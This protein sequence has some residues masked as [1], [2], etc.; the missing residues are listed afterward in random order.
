ME[1]NIEL[2]TC[3]DELIQNTD[4]TSKY[5]L[6]NPDY[7]NAISADTRAFIMLAS[8]L[9]TKGYKPIFWFDANSIA[10]DKLLELLNSNNI[11]D[12]NA[13]WLLSTSIDDCIL[14]KLTLVFTS[15]TWKPLRDYFKENIIVVM[16]ALFGM[17]PKGAKPTYNDFATIK[18]TQ[19][20]NIYI[21]FFQTNQ[22]SLSTPNYYFF[23]NSFS[24]FRDL[25]AVKDLQNFTI[26]SS[27]NSVCHF[28]VGYL[29]I[30]AYK[31]IKDYLPQK[32]VILFA[33]TTITHSEEFGH[34]HYQILETLG[35]NFKDYEIW[36]RPCPSNLS[37]NNIQ[38]I[39]KKCELFENIITDSHIQTGD[40][41]D[42]YK[43]T[44]ILVTDFASSAAT[45]TLTTSRPCIQ[46]ITSSTSL[47]L[48]GCTQVT[49]PAELIIATQELLTNPEKYGIKHKLKITKYINSNESTI[50]YI[51]RNI[52]K[53]VERKPLP[54]SISVNFFKEG[55]FSAFTDYFNFIKN[56]FKTSNN[57]VDLYSINP[58]NE[59]TLYQKSINII[60]QIAKI[61][62]KKKDLK[63]PTG[64]SIS[65][66]LT[67]MLEW[68]IINILNK[69]TNNKFYQLFKIR[70]YINAIKLT[71]SQTLSNNDKI[72]I[73]D[74]LLT[75]LFSKLTISE[76]DIQID[77]Y[78]YC[79]EIINKYPDNIEC[80]SW[81]Y[82]YLQSSFVNWMPTNDT[83]AVC[84]K[85]YTIR[86]LSWIGDKPG[87]L[88]E[89]TLLLQM[90]AGM[91]LRPHWFNGK[92]ENSE[93]EI[94]IGSMLNHSANWQLQEYQLFSQILL[95]II[96]KDKDT[97]Q[98]SELL[99]GLIQNHNIL[100]H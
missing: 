44:T 17:L 32:K 14:S 34:F 10:K 22:I 78:L 95:N 21:N 66:C 93:L 40:L 45:F 49:S 74:K 65:Q 92:W 7:Y 50:D 5:I 4:M 99:T 86:A 19:R 36:Y 79:Q 54:H 3:A 75:M 80:Q 57:Y 94:F 52:A 73:I 62:S 51:S 26:K 85:V 84:Y 98:L 9:L 2:Y 69:S 35:N 27:I 28:D 42:I 29:R 53:M 20:G 13:L 56:F 30:E 70:D 1:N 18:D 47:K 8:E 46:Y 60:L 68:Y 88:R 11:P 100:F 12:I 6:Y 64:K 31:S 63:L 23:S 39:L 89:F 76:S 48:T 90:N 72:H 37:I 96:S 33:P 82:Q 97:K 91:A 81:F 59:G 15:N 77:F 71:F 83:F 61:I 55:K 41:I 43:E 25:T 58:L 87:M 67:D 24:E 38:E 16:Y